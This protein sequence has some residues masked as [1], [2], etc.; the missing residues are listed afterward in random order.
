M[1]RGFRGGKEGRRER[2]KG[3]GGRP[4][5]LEGERE[6]EG[7]RRRD[8]RRQKERRTQLGAREKN[9]LSCGCVVEVREKGREKNGGGKKRK[10][11]KGD[12]IMNI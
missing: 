12:K 9:S 2:G 7:R 8:G 4:L 6:R 1:H 10:T 5:M 11:C 3:G